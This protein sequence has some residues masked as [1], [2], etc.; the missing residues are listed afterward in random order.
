MKRIL[1]RLALATTLLVTGLFGMTAPSAAQMERLQNE[2]SQNSAT[3]VLPPLQRYDGAREQVRGN[4]V[5]ADWRG[6]RR[7][8]RRDR[9]RRHYRQHRRYHR[10]HYRRGRGPAVYFDYGPSYRYVEPRYVQPRYV[11]PRFV[12]PAPRIRLSAAHVRWCHAR[13]R[14]YRSSDNTFQPYNGPRRQCYSPYS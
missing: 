10:D 2:A 1:S 7:H 6:D 9:D 11:A 5:R 13:Y 12:R 14:S 8:W 3:R 4:V